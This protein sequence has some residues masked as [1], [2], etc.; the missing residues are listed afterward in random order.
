MDKRINELIYN[1]YY[2]TLN[3][4]LKVIVDEDNIKTMLDLLFAN[5]FVFRTELFNEKNK[6]T[7]IEDLTTEVKYMS[8]E[9]DSRNCRLNSG[10]NI[11]LNYG[12]K[13]GFM[14][15]GFDKRDKSELD[16][17]QTSLQTYS[18]NVFEYL[19]D[20]DTNEKTTELS[21]EEIKLVESLRIKEQSYNKIYLSE[22]CL[23]YIVFLLIS[24]A[25]AAMLYKN[26]FLS[27]L[28]NPLYTFQD[29]AKFFEVIYYKGSLKFNG[30][31]NAFY[32]KQPIND[33]VSC[34]LDIF[35]KTFYEQE[36]KLTTNQSSDEVKQET[37]KSIPETNKFFIKNYDGSHAN[38]IFQSLDGYEWLKIDDTPQNDEEDQTISFADFKI[39]LKNFKTTSVNQTIKD[40]C[41][42]NEFRPITDFVSFK[43]GV[44]NKYIIAIVSLLVLVVILIIIIIVVVNKN[45]KLNLTIDILQHKE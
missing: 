6:V 17:I 2:V 23:M 35:M 32:T 5:E 10:F 43:G 20:R 24:Y 29:L 8:F 11:F 31:E 34:A 19:M 41:E 26:D 15:L 9:N 13:Q 39:V 33:G 37:L 1:T 7:S 28:N 36:Y 12:L 22:V 4:D 3:P 40:H 16:L 44:V 25:N 42:D 30:K 21:D 38:V 27:D 14:E 45:K 18:K